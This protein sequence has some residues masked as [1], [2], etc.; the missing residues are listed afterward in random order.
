MSFNVILWL[1]KRHNIP[2][3]HPIIYGMYGAIIGAL[4]GIFLP[5]V[6]CFLIGAVISLILTFGM[7]YICS[8]EIT[9][10]GIAMYAIIIFGT[11]TALPGLVLNALIM[12][13]TLILALATTIVGMCVSILIHPSRSIVYK[14][15]DRKWKMIRILIAFVSIVLLLI[16]ITWLLLVTSEAICTY[17]IVQKFVQ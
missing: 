9:Q 11:V 6:F 17:F 5:T 2:Y 14:S 12:P 10:S 1:E 15:E 4:V 7:N 8:V 13:I 3:D 16:L